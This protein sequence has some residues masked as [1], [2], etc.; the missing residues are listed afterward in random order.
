M[1]K[2]TAFVILVFVVS[3]IYSTVAEQYTLTMYGHSMEPTISDNDVVLVDTAANPTRDDIVVCKYSS[4][5]P[6]AIYIK[7]IIGVPG[8]SVY[9]K[10]GVTHLVFVYLGQTH[11][12]AIDEKFSIYFPNGSPDDYEEYQLGNNEFFVIGDNIYNSHDSRD[13][14]DSDPE[15]DV[16][17]ISKENI[18][19]IIVAKLEYFR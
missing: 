15:N 12:T 8:D 2:A 19:G 17:P 5:T 1:K 9:R 11:D 16:G 6:D 3:L 14:K 18:L 4:G 7:R 10:N 13:W